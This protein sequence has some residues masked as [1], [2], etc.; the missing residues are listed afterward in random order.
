MLSFSIDQIS[1][2]EK[3]GDVAILFYG[4]F[5]FEQVRNSSPLSINVAKYFHKCKN[6]SITSY[7]EGKSRAI[8]RFYMNSRTRIF[9]ETPR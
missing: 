3:C 4:V 7:H 1:L 9:N 2:R 6:V 5:K 8:H